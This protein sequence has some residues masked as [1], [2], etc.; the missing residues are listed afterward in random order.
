MAPPIATV[1]Q[2][3]IQYSDNG[4][5]LAGSDRLQSPVLHDCNHPRH[6]KVLK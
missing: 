1:D 4:A 3:A 6:Y 2:N 5:V